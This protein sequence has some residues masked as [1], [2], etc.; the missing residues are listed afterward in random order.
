MY[1]FSREAA[2][3]YAKQQIKQKRIERLK[4]VRAQA[5]KRSKCKSSTYKK[6]AA[7]SDMELKE[8]M[9]EEWANEKSKHLKAL[10]TEYNAMQKAKGMAHQSAQQNTEQN[11]QNAMENQR[12]WD[13]Q[14]TVQ[15]QRARE[16]TSIL[17]KRLIEEEQ[18][19]ETRAR[20]RMRAL[21]MAAEACEIALDDDR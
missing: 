16:A 20:C 11:Y 19:Q 10:R 2:D 17:Q 5:A 1:S 9:A 13:K 3:C 4:A 14:Q 18:A 6:I 8:E 15:A 21:Q 12:Q 7:A